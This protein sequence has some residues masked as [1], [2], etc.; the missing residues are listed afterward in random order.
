M[1]FQDVEVEKIKRNGETVKDKE[2]KE[3][4]RGKQRR[5][6]KKGGSKERFGHELKGEE[7][8]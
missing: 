4:E 8:K 2:K 7:E 1:K 6:Q 5:F 3:R